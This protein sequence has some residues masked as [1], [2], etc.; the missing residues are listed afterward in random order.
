MGPFKLAIGIST[1]ALGILVFIIPI[2]FDRLALIKHGIE[3][4]IREVRNL[5]EKAW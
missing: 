1:T 5:E 2:I 4:D 3:L